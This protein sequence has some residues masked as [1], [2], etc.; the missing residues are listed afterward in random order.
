M[1]EQWA[2]RSAHQQSLSAKKSWLFKAKNRHKIHV[3]F[4][5]GKTDTNV[6]AAF[7][8]F[9]ISDL[10]PIRQKRFAENFLYSYRLEES[11]DLCFLIDIICGLTPFLKSC[12]KSKKTY[13]W[14]LH[15]FHIIAGSGKLEN[16]DDY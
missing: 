1:G 2:I 10:T 16:G 13:V 8:F 6:L 5:N 11:F 9:Y 7:A 15:L 14:S 3:H 12:T 4:L